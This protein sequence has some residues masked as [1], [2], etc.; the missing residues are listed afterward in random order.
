MCDVQTSDEQFE[1]LHTVGGGGGGGMFFIYGLNHI[2]VVQRMRDVRRV[3][4]T[5]I[6]TPFLCTRMRI[7]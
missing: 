4:W 6:F 2:I 3:R 1:Q 7:F 5:T